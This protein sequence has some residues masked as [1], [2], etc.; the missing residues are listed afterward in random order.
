MVFINVGLRW[1]TLVN[2]GYARVVCQH[3]M[4]QG[5]TYRRTTCAQRTAY[6]ERGRI[7]VHVSSPPCA[8]GLERRPG[9]AVRAL[10]LGSGGAGGCA[11]GGR[12]AVVGHGLVGPSA[13]W[14]A[15]VT[16][17]TLAKVRAPAPSPLP[18]IPCPS[19]PLRAPARQGSTKITPT[20]P[21]PS[22]PQQQRHLSN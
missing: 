3:T 7:D 1:L 6:A 20:Q 2:V 12:V 15:H 17:G 13:G 18:L 16:T 8:Q 21:L 19:R 14:P 5:H 9:L 10:A 11:E 22:S 4:A